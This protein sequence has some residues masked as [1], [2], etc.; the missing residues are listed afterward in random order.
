[1]TESC[2]R[3]WPASLIGFNRHWLN[4]TVK[5]MSSHTTAVAVY[6]ESSSFV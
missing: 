4:S 5:G 1:M 2:R 3:G 6:E